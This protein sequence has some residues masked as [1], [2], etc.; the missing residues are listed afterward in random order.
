MFGGDRAVDLADDVVTRY[1]T[2]KQAE[3]HRHRRNCGCRSCR[4]PADKW[5]EWM[6]ESESER[7]RREAER[8]G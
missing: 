5:D 4:V 7:V 3:A 2:R 6:D 1:A 8:K